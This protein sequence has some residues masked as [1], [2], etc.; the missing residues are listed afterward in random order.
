MAGLLVIDFHRLIIVGIALAV[1]TFTATVQFLLAFSISC[2][3][4]TKR[5]MFRNRY[6]QSLLN[7]LFFYTSLFKAI[8][9]VRE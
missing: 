8:K 7:Q 3:D 2:R 4:I 6:E 5:G 1:R 9:K